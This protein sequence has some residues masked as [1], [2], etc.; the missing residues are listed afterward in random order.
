MGEWKFIGIK[1]E[2]ER[3]DF[4]IN[5]IVFA[6]Y[7]SLVLLT[8]PFQFHHLN[9]NL[10][11]VVYLITF[12]LHLGFDALSICEEDEKRFKKDSTFIL[13]P[14]ITLATVLAAFGVL[15]DNFLLATFSLLGGIVIYN[16]FRIELKSPEKTDFIWFTLGSLLF[17]VLSYLTSSG[18][19]G[20]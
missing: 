15:P 17:A 4:Q 16:V 18:I 14:S 11:R 1:V 9:S 6:I 10:S 13:L 8:L 5:L 3:T 20:H 2:E 19:S 12:I 7:S